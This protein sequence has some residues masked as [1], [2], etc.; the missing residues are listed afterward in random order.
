M[1]GSLA[2][3]ELIL[4]GIINISQK[5]RSLLSDV[6]IMLICSRLRFNTAVDPTVRSCAG[7]D[8]IGSEDYS[9]FSYSARGVADFNYVRYSIYMSKLNII[10]IEHGKG[11]RG[12]RSMEL[13]APGTGFVMGEYSRLNI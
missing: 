10:E 6:F 9:L 3:N 11:Q 4:I 5:S 2:D 1:E 13:I 12:Q 7:N 8:D